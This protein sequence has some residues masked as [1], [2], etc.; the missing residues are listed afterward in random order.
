MNTLSHYT[1]LFSAN[2]TVKSLLPL[3]EIG[4][5]L[6]IMD[7]MQVETHPETQLLTKQIDTWSL[8]PITKK[9]RCSIHTNTLRWTRYDNNL[10]TTSDRRVVS[11]WIR[12]EDLHRFLAQPS[13]NTN[14]QT[15]R[16]KIILTHT[17]QTL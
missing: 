7:G 3:L 5:H 10:L 8:Y 2:S 9:T 17:Q 14:I 1:H 4:D 13:I 6:C 15:L 12:D 11:C 16:N